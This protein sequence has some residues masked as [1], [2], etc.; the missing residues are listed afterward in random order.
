MRVTNPATR[1]HERISS[2]WELVSRT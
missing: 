2:G 1:S